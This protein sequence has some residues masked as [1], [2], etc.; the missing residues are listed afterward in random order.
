M[1][2]ILISSSMKFRSIA[3]RVINR[4]EKLGFDAR[5]PN[6]MNSDKNVSSART[7]SDKK[8]YALTHFRVM[9]KADVVYFIIQNGYIGNSC[10]V[11]L[12]YA[13]ALEKPIYFSEK[14]NDIDLDCFV[15]KIIPI[16]KLQ[17]FN[18][19]LK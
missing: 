11:E 2:I 8:K 16:N 18:K 9:E 13:L 15:K 1:K 5:F 12:G 14:A 4:L 7:I 17:I 6:L 3:K 10:K 19:E